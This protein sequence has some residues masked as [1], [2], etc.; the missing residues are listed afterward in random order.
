M[1]GE[2]DRRSF[3]K[4]V[5]LGIGVVAG[6][7]II[8]APSR[9]L[10][11]TSPRM[12]A[13]LSRP[14]AGPPPGFF[15]AGQIIGIGKDTVQLT[16]KQYDALPISV[17]GNARIWKGGDISLS[18]LT[19]GDYAYVMTAPGPGGRPTATSLWLNHTFPQVEILSR[20]VDTLRVKIWGRAEGE[21][22]LSDNTRVWIGGAAADGA[23]LAPGMAARVLGTVLP[24]KTLLA[25]QVYAAVTP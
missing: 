6:S 13:A 12:H 20:N 22:R 8:E 1:M 18:K 9:V 14:G 4:K 16:N 23:K 17:P 3:I 24:D 25:H 15:V 19:V 7:Q 11:S 2:I 10:A 5:G 21:I